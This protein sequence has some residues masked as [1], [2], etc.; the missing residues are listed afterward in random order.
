MYLSFWTL[1][2]VISSSEEK[3]ERTSSVSLARI[4][5]CVPRRNVT[6]DR[7]VAV[8][9]DPAMIKRDALDRICSGVSF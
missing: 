3:P 9:S 7:A 4:S 6:P 8:V 1:R 2:S 5:G